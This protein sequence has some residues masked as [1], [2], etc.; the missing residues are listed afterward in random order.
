M[1]CKAWAF[2]FLSHDMTHFLL[3]ALVAGPL[4][5]RLTLPLVAVADII[6]EAGAPGAAVNGAH[7]DGSGA[8]FPLRPAMAPDAHGA[9]WAESRNSSGDIHARG[10][11]I[12]PIAA[13]A[14]PAGGSVS[15][16]TAC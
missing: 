9:G 7:G 6:V 4:D 5:A 1:L 8:S 2:F 13:R 16:K 12:M 14:G 15:G 10:W 11:K 3:A